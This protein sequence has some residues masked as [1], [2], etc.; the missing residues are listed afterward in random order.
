M[1]KKIYKWL[2]IL[3]GV[4]LL[5]IWFV[6]SYHYSEGSR[7]GYLS[8]FDREGMVFKT[9]EGEVFMGGAAADNST[10]VNTTWKF[11]ARSGDE[12]LINELQKLEGK[13]VKAYY[14]EVL[15]ALPWQGK[16]NEFVY[17]VEYVRE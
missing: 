1:K 7:T 14:Y 10:L 13:V 4:G 5:Y 9:Y 8:K 11:S 16:N 6:S 15:D 2:A 12:A 3:A 17:K